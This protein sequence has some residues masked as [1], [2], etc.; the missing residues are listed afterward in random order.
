MKIS[1]LLATAALCSLAAS[2]GSFNL[3][4]GTTG[5]NLVAFDAPYSTFTLGS[6]NCGMATCTLAGTVTLSGQMLSWTLSMPNQD[7]SPFS[8][9]WS[10]NDVSGS[11]LF[12]T[13]GTPTTGFTL[14]DTLGDSVSGTFVLTDLYSDGTLYPNGYDGV[15]IDGT[16]TLNALVAGSNASAFE[17]LFGLGTVIPPNVNWDFTLDVGNCYSG[18]KARVCVEDNTSVTDPSATLQSFTI[19]TPNSSTPEPGT[20]GAVGMGLA[21]LGLVIRRKR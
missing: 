14:S 13:D 20:V 18:S 10:G 5:D 6:D 4:S 19:N 8:Y 11:G 7:L 9:I 17:N 15:N 1:N 21:L 3:G 12:F 2:A 16:I